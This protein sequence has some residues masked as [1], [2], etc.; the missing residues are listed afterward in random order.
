MSEVRPVHLRVIQTACKNTSP[1][2]PSRSGPREPYPPTRV[3]ADDVP[4]A[5]PGERRAEAALFGFGGELCRS[6][7][8]SSDGIRTYGAIACGYVVRKDD[9]DEAYP[10]SCG[11]RGGSEDY[12]YRVVSSFHG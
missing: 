12:P 3:H 1:S 9:R 5:R 10:Q 7:G 11:G 8:R 2:H 4:D 6:G